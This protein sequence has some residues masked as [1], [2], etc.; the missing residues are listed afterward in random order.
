MGD[1]SEWELMHTAPK[2]PRHVDGGRILVTRY[3]FKGRMPLD[4]VYWGR[5]AGR[6]SCWRKS[7]TKRLRYEPT[8]WRQLP[9]PPY[10]PA[11]A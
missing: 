1:M 9:E 10:R 8:H 11:E 5:G 6:V 2:L 3:P 4:I 7:R